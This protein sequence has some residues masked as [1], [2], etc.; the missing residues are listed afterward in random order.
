ML[1]NAAHT[2]LTIKC[3]YRTYRG[4]LKP[5]YGL[6]PTGGALKKIERDVIKMTFKESVCI[7]PVN[8]M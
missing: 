6:V 7:K 1:S 3:G 2:L 8:I 5:V 4:C